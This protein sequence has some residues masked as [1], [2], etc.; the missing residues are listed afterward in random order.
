MSLPLPL[1]INIISELTANSQPESEKQKGNAKLGKILINSALELSQTMLPLVL[2]YAQ[3]LNIDP[4]GETIPDLCPS[5]VVLE[6]I[7]IPVNNIIDKI[8]T[9]SDF[10]NKTGQILTISA[11]GASTLQSLAN[12][13]SSTLPTLQAAIVA[14]PPPGLPGAVVG[15]V[16]ILDFNNKNIILANDGTP[17]LPPILASVGA[18]NIGVVL[19]STTINNIVSILNKIIS[20][21]Q[22]C[23]PNTNIDNLS[24]TV[25]QII[26]SVIQSSLTQSQTTYNGFII[27]IEEKDYSPTVKQRRAVGQNYQGITLIS[28]PYSF[29]VNKQTLINELKLIIDRDN[30][31]AY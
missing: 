4:N 19:L 3:Q 28:T 27:N 16:D 11:A 15:S 8:N 23:L 17:K 2:T 5:L 24:D 10:L 26:N 18:A 30:L 31:K 6:K 12:L 9:T 13:I 20:L 25:N 22:K 7:V 21:L 29:T 1:D 14:I